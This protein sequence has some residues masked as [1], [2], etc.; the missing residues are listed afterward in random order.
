MFTDLTV[1]ETVR[2]QAIAEF[3]RYLELLNQF[4]STPWDRTRFL[5][6]A[7]AALL[8]AIAADDTFNLAFYNLGGV[9]TKLREVEE[10]GAL[11]LAE[12]SRSIAPDA[13]S[14]EKAR[15]AR[16]EAARVAFWKAIE[17]PPSRWEAHYAL[18][19]TH[20]AM[21]E[22]KRG[23]DP[24]HDT[25]T[26]K[27]LLRRVTAG[28]AHAAELARQ[29]GVATPAVVR[30]LEGRAA[31]RGNEHCRAIRRLR[32]ATAGF[33]LELCQ[34]EEAQRADPRTGE[35]PSRRAKHN[36]VAALYLLGV[37][38]AERAQGRS[39]RAHDGR[40]GGGTAHASPRTWSDRSRATGCFKYVEHRADASMDARVEACFKRAQILEARNRMR[41]AIK[42]YETAAERGN[43]NPAYIAAF[44]R[45]LAKRSNEPQQKELR[46][47]AMDEAARALQ[48]LAPVFR[49]S[50]LP[51]ASQS[52]QELC[53][54]TL[55][56]LTKMQESL[57]DDDGKRRIA[58]IGRL[59][60]ALV[61]GCAH[62]GDRS[63][64]QESRSDATMECLTECRKRYAQEM[65]QGSSRRKAQKVKQASS[66]IPFGR[67]PGV[68]EL[69]QIDMALARIYVHD[70]R[71]KD[72]EDSLRTA[73]KLLEKYGESQRVVDFGLLPEL[74]RVMRKSGRLDE[75]NVVISDALLRGPLNARGR[76]EAGRVHFELG[77][78]EEALQ[79]WEQAQCL[80]PSDARL[81]QDMAICQW[82]IA[83]L[84]S[85]EHRREEAL[86]EADDRLQAVL[87]LVGSEH[88][89]ASAW[90]HIWRGRIALQRG[91]VDDAIRALH[92]AAHTR[93]LGWRQS[94]P[95][96]GATGQE[97]SPEQLKAL[98]HAS[99]AAL[100]FLGEAYL[101][102]KQYDLAKEAF[103]RCYRV[104]TGE[105][106]TDL[107]TCQANLR[108][109][110]QDKLHK[111]CDSR[112][113]YDTLI[114]ADS[115]DELRW[116]AV[117]VRV[118]R[119]LVEARY[120]APQQRPNLA[121]LQT[122]LMA[123][124][125]IRQ[126]A[127]QVRASEN[128][129]PVLSVGGH[130]E[131]VRIESS[132]ECLSLCT[133]TME[134]LKQAIDGCAPGQKHSRLHL[135]RPVVSRPTRL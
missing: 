78:Y 105:G 128:A 79:Y 120:L 39:G 22:E 26:D 38:Y 122:A 16:L 25:A 111:L 15:K 21:L 29:S 85:D 82:R 63:R 74:A 72:A 56:D 3:T 98:S 68:W 124:E 77:Q 13:E 34:A 33:W 119:G 110:C 10:A 42:H 127:A 117:A 32:Y 53:D 92:G 6:K 132:A 130:A 14:L 24:A 37:A 40:P 107:A 109:L 134:R 125:Q 41:Q 135:G 73:K 27:E 44:A 31:L 97:L 60:R 89:V 1:R 59:R 118:F 54:T 23:T 67:M 131:Q 86:R 76:W 61:D 71:W 50:V 126:D 17:K 99:I 101:G 75:A 113:E 2:W 35:T 116:D 90:A 121:G 47:R 58:R 65:K 103:S 48:E 104:M 129:A 8:K 70:A 69:V 87:E 91:R 20:F 45:A 4:R 81:G 9:Y 19:V 123:M 64:K 46:A 5:K 84:A 100:A 112:D 36:A 114:D 108:E 7:E 106:P 12:P 11:S 88:P 43:S 66:R 28:C 83:S 18:A 96:N 49:R 80:E 30:Q 62:T 95:A 57:D 51:S 133:I 93:V 102:T 55:E 52:F 94:V 115:G